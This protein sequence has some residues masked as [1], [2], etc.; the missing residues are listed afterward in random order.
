MKSQD[1]KTYHKMIR[2]TYD[3]R[4]A[5]HDRSAWHR[6]MAIKLF[7]ALPPKSGDTVLDIATGT[8]TI[9]FKA[10]P[11][12]G[13]N[14]QVFAIDISRGMLNEAMDKLSAMAFN[15]MLFVLA[16][17][18]QNVFR[19]NSFDRIYCASAFFCILNPLSTLRYWHRLLKKQGTLAFHALP[20]QSY[21]WIHEA[22][23]ILA[24][25]GYP[26]LINM[27]TANVDSSRQLLLD[28]GFSRVEIEVESSGYY[29]PTE[30]ALDSWISITDFIPG[31]AP[32][33]VRDIPTEV[34]EQFKEEYLSRIKTLITEHGVWN[35]VT[36]YYIYAYK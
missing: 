11:I 26:Y 7:Q 5:N 2:D 25:H 36:Q 4:S 3:Q 19:E 22:R 33:P 18:E 23:Q 29:V 1:L 27:A 35:D 32:H 6:N 16:N 12:V 10:S 28:A 20:E 31:Q 14:G 21:F 8:G 34:L 24:K 9:A 17:A 13:K 30:Q 15:N